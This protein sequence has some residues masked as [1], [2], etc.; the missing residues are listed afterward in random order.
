MDSE[1]LVFTPNGTSYYYNRS[2][3]G[4]VDVL[5]NKLMV[6]YGVMDCVITPSGMCAISTL[7]HTLCS[8]SA[9]KKI[10]LV[11]SSELYQDS[12][13]LFEHIKDIYGDVIELN[14]FDID[15]QQSELP[16]IFCTFTSNDVVILFVESCSNPNSHTFDFDLIPQLR[17]TKALVHVI[18]DNTWLSSAIFNPFRFGVD[19]VVTSLTKY[20]SAGTAIGGAIMGSG[21]WM[22]AVFDWVRFN[23][24]HVSPHNAQIISDQMETIDS[25]IQ[26]SSNLTLKVLDQIKTNPKIIDLMHPSLPVN[27]GYAPLGNKVYPV[28]K[29]TDLPAPKGD[30]VYP[31]AKGTDLPAPQGDK[32]Y[33]VAKGTDLPAPQ[34][35]KVYVQVV[36]KD[37]YPSIFT[38]VVKTS[39]N[40]AL[41]AMQQSTIIEHKTS[42]GGFTTR[43]DPWPVSSNGFVTCRF[44]IGYGSELTA[45]EIAVEINHIVSKM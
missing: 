5:R 35:D 22:G 29:G 43:T 32:V 21:K 31:V 14:P 13:R 39:K 45:D 17:Q 23:G 36:G 26:T 33:P 18:V 27:P 12:P 3:S 42:F 20:Y 15:K 37:L 11:Y 25:R 44:S 8:N 30:K 9:Y 4:P 1:S 19:F 6:R 24:L 28:A 34:G 40:K 10:T 2:S 41:K 38:V 7:L 16:E